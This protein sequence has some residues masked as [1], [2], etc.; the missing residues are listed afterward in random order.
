MDATKMSFKNAHL[1]EDDTD[2]SCYYCLG[3]FKGIEVDVYVDD[4]KTAIC[5]K[6]GIDSVLTEDID[7]DK[8]EKINEY[9]FKGD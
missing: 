9:Y 7:I 4:G 2:C 8:L 6:C 5:P 3:K 1:I